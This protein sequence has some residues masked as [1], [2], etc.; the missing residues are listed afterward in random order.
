MPKGEGRDAKNHMGRLIIVRHGETKFN[1]EDRY[2][3][4]EDSPLSETGHA[5]ARALAQRAARTGC[6]YIYSS[7]LGR[8]QQTAAYI[9]AAL[10]LPVTLDQRLRERNLGVFEGL[11]APELEAKYPEEFEK[12]K[13]E[14]Q[15]FVVP[16]GE[17]AMQVQHRAM[18]CLN[19]LAWRHKEEILVVSHGGLLSAVLRHVLAIS[20]DAPRR[21][22]RPN[23]S[24]NVFTCEKGRWKLETWGD[25]SHLELVR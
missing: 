6:R 18:E 24:W 7:D 11:T 1:A 25:V 3:G 22:H 5:Q 23:A 9:S 16:G 20:N 8:A 10:Q 15:S 17:S 21:F 13:T 12:Y 4:Q 2:Q 14:D 19:E